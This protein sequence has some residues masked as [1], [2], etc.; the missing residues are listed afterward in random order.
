MVKVQGTCYDLEDATWEHQDSMQ[1]A[2][3][4]IFGVV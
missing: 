1:K 4:H 3:L 2:Y